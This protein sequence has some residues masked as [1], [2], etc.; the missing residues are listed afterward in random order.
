VR[1]WR[2]KIGGSAL[3]FRIWLR[4]R[5]AGELELHH[6]EAGHSLEVADIGR[7]HAIAKLERSHTDKQAGKSNAHSSRLILAIDFSRTKG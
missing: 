3:R 7:A 6:G 1:I 4:V 2:N 5:R